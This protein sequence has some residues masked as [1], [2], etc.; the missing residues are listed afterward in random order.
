METIYT[1]RYAHANAPLKLRNGGI[2]KMG[3]VEEQRLCI[4]LPVHTNGTVLLTWVGNSLGR[5]PTLECFLFS[6]YI[7][8]L[9]D[10]YFFSRV[11]QRGGMLHIGMWRTPCTQHLRSI[12]P[13]PTAPTAAT[14]LQ[15]L[16]VVP[17]ADKLLVIL[18]LAENDAR[19]FAV[20]LD[21]MNE[22]GEVGEVAFA[23]KNANDNQMDVL[24]IK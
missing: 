9:F 15:R 7:P 17:A 20:E 12:Y 5:C 2:V 19:E 4:F 6:F 11:V 13:A 3:H 24:I 16:E 22:V 23:S 21:G 1:C 18:K 8:H 14:S 10:G